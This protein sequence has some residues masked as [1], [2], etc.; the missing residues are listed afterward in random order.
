MIG[1]K[2]LAM[3]SLVAL[4][5]CAY[6]YDRAGPALTASL[7]APRPAVVDPADNPRTPEKIA[8]G[9]DLFNDARLSGNGAQSC[10][11]CHQAERGF[12][13][14]QALSRGADG[15]PLVRHTPTLWNI[16]YASRLFSDGRAASLEEQALM[17]I[18]NGAEMGRHPGTAIDPIRADTRY[19]L[20]FARAFPDSPEVNELNVAR[21]LAA[22]ERTL[23]SGDTPYD[24]WV[25]GD[26]NALSP[27]ARRG[28]EVFVGRGGCVQCHS[29]PNFTDDRFHDIGLP[30]EDLGRGAMTGKRAQDHAFRTPGLR[31]V[32]RTAPYM[33]DG[34]LPTLRAV[35]DH[36]SGHASRRRTAPPARQLSEAERADLV[37]FLSALSAD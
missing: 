34:S 29:G 12:G 3:A 21:A 7:R 28:F 14:G 11:S 24:R 18:T 16:A 2:L 5:A 32:S 10:A 20:R 33:H 9:R 25:R 31:E 17:P 26:A 8:L 30:D 13:D 6:G 22:Y 4:G 36:Y 15:R 35:V 37:D 19:R 23:V 27:A 1:A